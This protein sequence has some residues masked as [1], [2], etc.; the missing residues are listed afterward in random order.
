MKY[1]EPEMEIIRFGAHAD[2]ITTSGNEKEIEGRDD[3]I[4]ET[5][6]TQALALAMSMLND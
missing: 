4:D 1:I 5:Q 3:P 2:I 6:N